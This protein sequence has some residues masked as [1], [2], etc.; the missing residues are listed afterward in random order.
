M[1]LLAAASLLLADFQMGQYEMAG[2]AKDISYLGWHGAPTSTEQSTA[3]TKLLSQAARAEGHRLRSVARTQP[4][5][6]DLV[7]QQALELEVLLGLAGRAAERAQGILQLHLG[8]PSQLL[9]SHQRS[10][11][12][13]YAAAAAFELNSQKRAVDL[14]L[15]GLAGCRDDGLTNLGWSSDA[16]AARLDE[17]RQ[18]GEATLTIKASV[19]GAQ[20]YLDGLFLGALPVKVT[21]IPAGRHQLQLV[22]G[23]AGLAMEVELK[24]DQVAR[25]ELT[26][27][28]HG[29]AG[30]S[31]GRLSAAELKAL[32]KN[33]PR[34]VGRGLIVLGS[35][36]GLSALIFSASQALVVQG[37]SEQALAA[38]VQSGLKSLQ[39]L[40][41]GGLVLKGVAVSEGVPERSFERMRQA[42]SR[43][44]LPAP[45]DELVRGMVNYAA[46]ATGRSASELRAKVE[47]S[48]KRGAWRA[49]R[50]HW[51][52]LGD[53][54]LSSSSALGVGAGVSALRLQPATTS[55]LWYALGVRLH[56]GGAG[57]SPSGDDWDPMRYPMDPITATEPTLEERIRLEGAGRFGVDALAGVGFQLGSD[58]RLLALAEGG[59]RQVQADLVHE[60]YVVGED[61]STKELRR[62][63]AFPWG[64]RRFG[65]QMLGVYGLGAW[66]VGGS[67]A[68]SMSEFPAVELDLVIPAS[69]QSVRLGLVVGRR[70]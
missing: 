9:R 68:W 3:L 39:P 60:Q 52:V 69:S 4:A 36:S 55:S 41:P 28:Q 1:M 46:Q 63:G 18:E 45:T 47:L 2:T 11:R 8:R 43:D 17:M 29:L 59:W 54:E 19:P 33:L 21:G 44:E 13:F 31:D 16:L 6:D 7:Q 48:Q 70:F 25:L 26:E 58:L 53:L 20:A 15:G 14:M 62:T 67:L 49:Q 64:G 50:G 61:G 22:S 40:P 30:L 32:A 23:A 56:A 35:R 34:G 27:P 10:C 24:P 66:Q 51:L 65:A 5:V 12:L 37:R 42:A 57:A 38:A